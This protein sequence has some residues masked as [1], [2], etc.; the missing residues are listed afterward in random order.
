[1]RRLPLGRLALVV[2]LLAAS[3]WGAEWLS[4]ADAQGTGTALVVR[5][6]DGDTIEVEIEGASQTV[7]LM[8]VDTPE[9]KHPTRP[10]EDV[11]PEVAAV[12]EAALTGAPVTLTVDAT[13]DREDGVWAALAVRRGAGRRFQRGARA[14]RIRASGPG[15]F[16]MRGGRSS[17]RLKMMRGGM[18]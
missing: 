12:T 18:A 8:G 7:R 5:V 6:M 3:L 1:M 9:T 11:G 14:G 16:S 4:A 2:A 13:G 10:G 17:S 15:A